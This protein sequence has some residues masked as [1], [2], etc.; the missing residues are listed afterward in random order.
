MR[1]RTAVNVTLSFTETLHS[2]VL[3][4]LDDVKFIYRRIV[5]TF[6]PHNEKQKR[7]YH[8]HNYILCSPSRW[9]LLGSLQSSQI[10][11]E[12]T[13]C[14]SIYTRTRKWLGVFDVEA[15]PLC[16]RRNSINFV[17][18]L[19]KDGVCLFLSLNLHSTHNYNCSFILKNLE[20]LSFVSPGL[21][22][23]HHDHGR[24]ITHRKIPVLSKQS[25]NL[26]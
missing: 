4:W 16:N 14:R 24:L 11:L 20:T 18:G 6:V 25:K 7:H 12:S 23:Q 1:S 8:G 22:L 10:K 15:R 13:Y 21:T 5:S 17:S 19:E 2:R 3:Q 26:P 9:L